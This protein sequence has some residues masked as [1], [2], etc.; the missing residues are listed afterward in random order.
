MQGIKI[1]VTGNIARVIEKPSRITSGT[2]GLPIEFTFDSQ[3]DGLRKKALFRSG[4]IIKEVNNLETGITVPWEVLARPKV[5]LSVGVYGVNEDGTV[6]IPTIWA[7]VLVI[8]TG[9]P[10]G[11]DHTTEPNKPGNAIGKGENI[12]TVIKT[13]EKTNKT[14]TEIITHLENGGV[15]IL[16][17]TNT[18]LWMPIM[19][20]EQRE[21]AYAYFITPDSR[22]SHYEIDSQGFALSVLHQYAT[23][24]QIDAIHKNMAYIEE[25]AKKGGGGSA[26]GAVLYNEVQ[27]LDV[28]QQERAR[29]NIGAAAADDI[30]DISTAFDDLHEYAQS[31]GGTTET[32]IETVFDGYSENGNT[33]TS[34]SKWA[35]FILDE[36][37]HGHSKYKNNKIHSIKL[38]VVTPGTLSIGRIETID[39]ANGTFTETLI[40]ERVTLTITNT[41]EQTVELPTPIIVNDDEDLF[42]G[43][44][45]DTATFAYGNTEKEKGFFFKADGGVTFVNQAA[46]INISV[47]ASSE[48]KIPSGNIETV[49]ETVFDGYSP[50]NDRTSQPYFAPFILDEA[51]HDH[52]NYKNKNLVAIKVYIETAG[53]LSIG[54]IKTINYSSENFAE[55]LIVERISL[56]VEN[57]GEQTINFP[58]TLVVNSDEDLF[59]GHSSDTAK[60]KYGNKDEDKAQGFFYKTS[61]GTTFVNQGVSLGVSIFAS[62]Q[63][64]I[65]DGDIEIPDENKVSNAYQGKK[66]SILGDSISTFQGYIPEGYDY[67]Y[68]PK[69]HSLESVEQTW[70]KMTLNALGMDLDTNNSCS[71]S[72][73]SYVRNNKASGLERCEN[74]GTPDVII[75]WMGINDFIYVGTSLGSY[76]GKT[77]IPEEA[78]SMDF[79]SA[80][81]VMLNK[82][83]SEHPTAEVWVC[84]LPTTDHAN[85]ETASDFPKLNKKG[86][87]VLEYNTAIKE[88]AEAFSVNVIELD[89]CGITWQNL[90]TFT[91]DKLHPNVEG[92]LKVARKVVRTLDPTVQHLVSGGA[93]E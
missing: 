1:E 56:N 72:C 35:P 3:W 81:A 22:V 33:K 61:S 65:P 12:L 93:S 90:V 24:E 29:Q 84:T 88:L 31:L 32:V 42:I 15:A 82:I 76:D 54:R 43:Y 45:T 70:W 89:K 41:G 19:V 28:D 27:D 34:A 23:Q 78:T 71:G 5:W 48:I 13:N 58:K 44:S 20:D 4:H 7:N 80:Y 86:N 59:V 9:V 60:I 10:S 26:E 55:E 30:G 75:V 50:N 83:L 8:N 66:L 37:T 53:T 49:I 11:G 46:S 67:W 52:K 63:I 85:V 25:L 57:T 6:A 16:Y 2:V 79:R 21:F 40:K 64:E 87:T 68:N 69:S 39:Y 91:D 14:S 51:V 17:D 18:G 36:A 38:N 74:L 62:S 92:H 73:V 47:F 77:A